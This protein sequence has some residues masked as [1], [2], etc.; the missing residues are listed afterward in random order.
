VLQREADVLAPHRPD[1]RDLEWVF[2]PGHD[3]NGNANR[4]SHPAIQAHPLWLDVGKLFDSAGKNQ[5]H[6]LTERVIG[7]DDNRFADAAPTVA[8]RFD[9]N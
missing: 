4:V 5:L 1:V 3:P 9:L 2:G 8:G 7:E 6:D